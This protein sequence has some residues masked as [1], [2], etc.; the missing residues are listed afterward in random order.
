[1]IDISIVARD[2][3]LP[4]EQVKKTIQLLDEGNTIPFITRFRK[5]ETG[6]LNE[7]QILAVKQRTASLRVLEDRKAFVLKSVESQGKLTDALKTS[8]EKASTSRQ[9][10]DIYLPLKANLPM[11]IWPHAPP[12]TCGSTKV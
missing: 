6:G 4:P 8:I 3:N 1:M 2:L 12:I 10:E 5:D 9:L 7:E 11:W